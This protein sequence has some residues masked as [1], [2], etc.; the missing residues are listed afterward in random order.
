MNTYNVF[1]ENE[2][3]DKYFCKVVDATT[4]DEAIFIASDDFESNTGEYV[5]NYKINAVKL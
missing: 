2:K 3:E 4:R 1:F 5:D